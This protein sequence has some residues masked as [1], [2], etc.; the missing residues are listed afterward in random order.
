[1]L[2]GW[3]IHNAT[4]TEIQVSSS[5]ALCFL[6]QHCQQWGFSL[7]LTRKEISHLIS[8][9]KSAQVTYSSHSNWNGR[10]E[11]EASWNKIRS[12]HAQIGFQGTANLL[13]RSGDLVLDLALIL[14]LARCLE[15]LEEPHCLLDFLPYRLSACT[16]VFTWVWQRRK[17]HLHWKHGPAPRT[18][19]KFSTLFLGTSPH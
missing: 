10:T 6:V 5:P 17:L 19:W 16:P 15:V 2:W 3:P 12:S 4:R 9:L 13:T 14:K 11:E 8:F 18:E 1:M 7:C